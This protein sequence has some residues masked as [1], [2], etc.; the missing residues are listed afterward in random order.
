MRENKAMDNQRPRILAIDDVPANLLTLGA[1][2]SQEF[3]LQVATSGL[4]GLEIA[5]LAPPDLILLDVMMP[6]MDGFEVC[7]RLKADP[8]L[9]DI[10]VIFV[11]ALSEFDSE[12]QG[13]TLG[14]ADYITKPFNVQIAR[15]RIRNLLERENLRRE[16][17]HLAFYDPLTQLS[18]RR[19]LSDRLLQAIALGKRS[20]CCGALIFLDLDNFKPLNDAQGHPVGDL[21]L[22][23]AANRLKT[24]VRE[25]DTVARFG[26][27]EFVVLLSE[28]DANPVQARE[29]A[30]RVAEKIRLVLAQPYLLTIR[31]H[32]ETDSY[33]EHH[34]T[35]SIGAAIFNSQQ[36]SQDDFLNWAD[37]AM[38]QAKEAGR[39]T[40]RFYEPV[41]Q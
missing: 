26:G 23:E 3:N 18:N 32:G 33:L 13:L 30:G 22:L 12:M 21:L 9:K 8:R 7:R 10:P 5:N 25:V 38:Y 20:A 2:L 28:L 27:D 31:R 34:C 29:Q 41:V 6:G 19:L 24:C 14:A 16:V 39:N 1:A 40:V 4:M 11:T 37:R 17:Q 35:A 15:Q 36:G